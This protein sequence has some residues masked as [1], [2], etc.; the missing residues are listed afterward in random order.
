MRARAAA[1]RVGES[2]LAPRPDSPKGGLCV[3]TVSIVSSR[4]GGLPDRARADQ[5]GAIVV[6]AD[7]IGWLRRRWSCPES[8]FAGAA[9]G[10]DGMCQCRM[11]PD[12]PASSAAF[13]TEGN[14]YTQRPQERLRATQAAGERAGMFG[15]AG[16]EPRNALAVT[17]GAGP[18]KVGGAARPRAALGHDLAHASG[19]RVGVDDALERP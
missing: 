15:P 12:D 9:D 11:H 14:L 3:S 4:D 18:Q 16:A 6:A 10:A 13:P 2:Q 5:I 19:H 17:I 8:M 7:V 1:A